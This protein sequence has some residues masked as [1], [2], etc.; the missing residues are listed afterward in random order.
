MAKKIMLR[1]APPSGDP[2][3]GGKMEENVLYSKGRS[4]A[5]DSFDLQDKIMELLSSNNRLKPADRK[6]IYSNLQTTLGR[7]KADK[8]MNHI[9]IFN[10]RAD[11]Q[12][13]PVEDKIKAFYSIG[14][15]DPDIQGYIDRTKSLGYGPQAQFRGSLSEI[16]SQLS[17]RN[18]IPQMAAE[19]ADNQRKIMLSVKK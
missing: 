3:K 8:L 2:V 6:S 12:N 14:S 15:N 5:D 1:I 16:N 18:P 4:G 13:M 10:T 19:P 9:Y 11:M 17:G 7:D